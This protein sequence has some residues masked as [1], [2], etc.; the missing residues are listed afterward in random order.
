MTIIDAF[1]LVVGG[2]G[3]FFAAVF[4]APLLY[5]AIAVVLTALALACAIIA[6]SAFTAG[7]RK[8]GWSLLATA[9]VEALLAATLIVWANSSCSGLTFTEVCA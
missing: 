6:T 2:I 4:G 1:L 5:A 7:D 9:V 3:G 8:G